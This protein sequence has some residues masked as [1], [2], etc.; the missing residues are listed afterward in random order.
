VRL[1][2]KSLPFLLKRPIRSQAGSKA[3]TNGSGQGKIQKKKEID[4]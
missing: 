3:K 2:S 4:K 1:S